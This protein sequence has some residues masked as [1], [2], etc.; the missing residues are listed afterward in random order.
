MR[1]SSLQIQNEA[2]ALAENQVFEQYYNWA[3]QILYEQFQ[4]KKK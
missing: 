3:I 4:K 2:R 1:I